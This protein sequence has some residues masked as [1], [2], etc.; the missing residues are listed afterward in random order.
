MHK[1]QISF[2][3]LRKSVFQGL[4]H[5]RTRE[6]ALQALSPYDTINKNLAFTVFEAVWN[7]GLSDRLCDMALAKDGYVQDKVDAMLSVF[8]DLQASYV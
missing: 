4:L 3:R 7:A 8:P 5:R 1:Q 6:V 2:C